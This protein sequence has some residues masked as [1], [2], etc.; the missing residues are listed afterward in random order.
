MRR[1]LGL[2]LLLGVA[3]TLAFASPASAHNY[4]VSSTPA[5]G[6]TVTT[7]PKTVE[8][9]T[10]DTLLDLAGNGNGF[11]LIVRDSAGAYYGD[12]CVTISGATISTD[13][14]LGAPGKYTV[15]WQVVSTDSHPVSNTYEFI[16]APTD[17]TQQT[18]GSTTPPDCHGTRTVSTPA[19]VTEAST[20]PSAG[21]DTTVFWI[22]GIVLLLIVAA[23]VTLIVVRPKRS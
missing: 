16:W 3:A 5:A 17:A 23:G 18:A 21:L 20:T 14:A 12:G 1:R 19:P 15:T 13:A 2:G 10:N 4:L 8:V 22:G 11:D 7:L 9:T 6:S